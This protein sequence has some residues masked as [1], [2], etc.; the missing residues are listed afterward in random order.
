MS[1][2]NYLGLVN[3]I[4]RR[5]N[6]VELTE[7]NF[8]GAVGFYS[9]AKDSVNSAIRHINLAQYEWPFNHTEEVLTL[10]A[11]ISRYAYPAD[12]KTLDFDSFRIKRSDTFGNATQKL[13]VLN[14]EEYLERYIDDE[15]NSA[16]SIRTLPRFVFRA[17]DQSFGLYPLPDKAY[18]LVYEYYKNPVDLV[19]ATDVPTLPEQFRYIIVDGAMFYSY[20]FRGNSQDAN[21][22]QQKFNEGIKHMRS[23]YVN[24]YEYLRDTRIPSNYTS[25]PRVK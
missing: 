14:Y 20:T 15:Y 4:N 16:T 2:Y 12:A 24:R 23:L 5:L 6:E 7:A 3:N 17:P 21:V 9:E 18:E 1:D 19:A 8:A 13:T 11:G 22:Y 25:G 10:T